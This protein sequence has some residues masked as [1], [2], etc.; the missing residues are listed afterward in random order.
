MV[1]LIDEID[2]A[3]LEFPNDL[4]WEL[5][6]MEFYIP[7]PD[8]GRV[9]APGREGPEPVHQLR[10]AGLFVNAPELP[11]P[12]KDGELPKE[13]LDWLDRPSEN[14]DRTLEE[15]KRAGFSEEKAEELLSSSRWSKWTWRMRSI[16]SWSGK[17]I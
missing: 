17:S 11:D 3:D 16:C 7:L 12:V 15:L 5:D 13:L 2:K 1:L 14:L 9:H 6:Q 8:P 4:L 10:G